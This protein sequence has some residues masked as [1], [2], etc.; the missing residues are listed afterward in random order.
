MNATSI[1][2]KAHLGT[3]RNQTSG[4]VH[5]VSFHHGHDFVPFAKT[6]RPNENCAQVS[7]LPCSSHVDF[8]TNQRQV[9]SNTPSSITHLVVWSLRHILESTNQRIRLLDIGFLRAVL[10]TLCVTFI[11]SIHSC[12]MTEYEVFSSISTLHYYYLLMETVRM[13]IYAF[14]LASLQVAHIVVRPVHR[15]FRSYFPPSFSFSL[16]S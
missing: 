7:M 11:L 10:F 3:I 6:F 15:I 2:A 12:F 4:T 13:D 9:G 16:L 1:N 5:T 8:P 14:F